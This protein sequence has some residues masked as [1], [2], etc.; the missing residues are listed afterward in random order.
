MSTEI[1]RNDPCPC[2]SGKKHKNCCYN[3]GILTNKKGQNKIALGVLALVVV[4][5]G[6]ISISK[7][8]S[9]PSAQKMAPITQPPISPSAT[10]STAQTQ[11]SSVPSTAP[12]FT[13]QP[14]GPVPMGKVWSPEHGHWH[15]V[16]P[17]AT[18]T[19]LPSNNSSTGTTSNVFDIL[20]GQEGTQAQAKLTPQPPGPV[21]E[22]K[23]WSAEHGHWHN[24]PAAGQVTATN[25][26]PGQ[27]TQ[28]TPQPPGPAPAGKVWS[29]EHGHWHDAPVQPKVIQV[30]P[31]NTEPK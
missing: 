18:A 29:A 5:A 10:T 22:G 15:N 20:P 3:R 23:V 17:A 9:T 4:L 30:N 6:I 12:Q 7:L 14:P 8:S 16:Q 13:P 27:P 1:G 19:A 28:L 31:T 25:L 11:S 2:G 26:Q 21:P 24:I